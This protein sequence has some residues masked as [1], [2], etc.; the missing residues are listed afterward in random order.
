MDSYL[1]RILELGLEDG[2]EVLLTAK[3]TKEMIS[4][5]INEV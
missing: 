5:K 4:Q 2:G 3:E 1:G